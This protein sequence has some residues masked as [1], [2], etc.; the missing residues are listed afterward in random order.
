[1]STHRL[2][3]CVFHI[4]STGCQRMTV[5]GCHSFHSKT[6]FFGNNLDD[7]YFKSSNFTWLSLRGS[8]LRTQH[9]HHK[10]FKVSCVLPLMLACITQCE[11]K[12][13]NHYGCVHSHYTFLHIL[14]SWVF[15]HWIKIVAT[16]QCPQLEYY[17]SSR[18]H[19]NTFFQ[20]LQKS[21]HS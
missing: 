17:H 20:K 8:Q 6:F 16:L 21:L 11:R 13:T 5:L 15:A 4:D 12:S 9:L 2:A 10:P 19:V 7:L 3:S 14:E 18:I 1:M